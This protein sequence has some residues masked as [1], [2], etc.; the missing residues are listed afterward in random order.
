[1]TEPTTNAEPFIVFELAGTAYGLRSR[2]VRHLEMLEHVTPVPNAAPFVEGV[3]FS[4]GQVIPV[5]SLRARFGLERAP[6]DLR[7]RLLVVQNEQR[8]VGLV[9]DSAREFLAFPANAIQPPHET[10]NGLS[11]RYLEGIATLGERI[12]LILNLAETLNF[13]DAANAGN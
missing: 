1:M 9:T 13:A 7:T 5:V 2:D 3:V 8:T 10:I 12:V 4:R 6:Y 11:G